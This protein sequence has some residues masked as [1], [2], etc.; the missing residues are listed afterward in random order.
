MIAFA[1]T[2]FLGAFLLFL[3]QPLIGKFILPWFG[4]T[5]AVWT[6]CMLFFQVLL[7]AGYAYAHASTRLL[8]PRVQAMAHLGL[9]ALALATLP[10]V[11]ALHWKPVGAGSPTWHILVLLTAT[12]GLPYFVLSA[13]GPLLQQWFTLARAGRSPYRL[14]ALSNAG[15]LLALLSYPFLVEPLWTRQAQAI[16]WSWGLGLYAL[17]T[18][19]CAVCVW[20]VGTTTAGNAA[21][22]VPV[23]GWEIELPSGT[24]LLWLGLPATASVLLLAFTNKMCLDVAVIP[25]L[26]VLPLGLYLLSFILCFQG[27]RWYPRRLCQLALIPSVGLLC[28]IL[29]DNNARLI[30]QIAIYGWVLFNSCMVCHG[31]LYRLR[32]PPCRLTAFYLVIA[33]GGAVGGVLVALVAP[34]LFNDYLEVHWGIVL[35]VVVVAIIHRREGTEWSIAGGQLP[36]WKIVQAAGVALAVALLLQVWLSGRAQVAGIRNFYGVLKIFEKHRDDP[37]RHGL[38]LHSGSTLHGGQLIPPALSRLPTTYYHEQSG[39]GLVMRL[40]PR[41]ENR[42]IGVVG[43]GVGTLAAWGR[44]GDLLRFYEI[45]PEVRRLAETHFTFLRGS[46]AR[47]EIVMGDARLSLEKEPPQQYDLLVLDAFS[48]DA[49]PTHLLTREAFAAYLRHLKPDGVIAAHISNR[50][51]NLVPVMGSLASWLQMESAM[52]ENFPEHPPWWLNHSRWFLLSRNKTL[53]SHPEITMASTRQSA[54]QANTVLWTD[55][56]T[57]LY[58]LLR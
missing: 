31:E 25:F 40:S 46:P 32:P 36:V 47:I 54:A 13:T 11:P 50:H 58:P 16:L 8:R 26:W 15:S 49:I 5:P 24:K 44:S 56:H 18:A 55:D 41:Q 37:A 51:L 19:A 12:L 45:N 27:V 17:L 43:L 6:A 38:V 33:A 3:V 30:V 53:M 42:R 52:V 20:R 9:V 4:G 28:Y 34:L 7:L 10:I 39:L 23:A 35:L 48:S 22:R 57:S 21:A 1:L 14:Y 29:I 2:I